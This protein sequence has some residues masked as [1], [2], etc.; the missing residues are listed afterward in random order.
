MKRLTDFLERQT[1]Q[2]LTKRKALRAYQAANKVKRTFWSEVRGWADALVFAVFAVLLIN[3]YLFQLFVIPS[4]SMVS[5]LNI[6]DRVFVSKTIFGIEVYPGGPK[7]GS[8][9]RQIGRDQIITFYN[10]EY[11]SKGP[12]F[13][14][15]S[16]IIYMGTF[17]LVNIDRNPDG[18]MAERLYVKRAIGLPSEQV[19][20]IDG[21]VYLRPAG[22]A[23]WI[24]EPTFRADLG[25]VDGPHRS[26]AD[27]QYSGIRAWGTLFGYQEEGIDFALLPA[28]LK[29]EYAKVS[30]YNYPPDMYAFEESRLRAR[31]LFDPS[32]MQSRSEWASYDR[33][34]YVPTDHILPLGDNRD[35]S[36]DGRYFGPV[37]QRSINGSV[38]SRFWPLNRI[39]YLG[40]K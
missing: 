9:N 32:N 40:N 28:S 6:G 21:E 38:R 37:T 1:I 23:T 4:P 18:S 34:I 8:T 33:G 14:V 26:L 3:Q 10:P 13:D 11:T 29:N 22:S 2:I 17:S 36:R 39:A 16:Q 35:N 20:F 25:L 27:D 5:T 7:I 19:K 12:F 31:H 24:A 15:L 30:S